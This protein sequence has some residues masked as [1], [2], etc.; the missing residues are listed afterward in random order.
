MTHRPFQPSVDYPPLAR[1]LSAAGPKA[2][3]PA[4][5]RAQDA[6]LP[7][8]GSLFAGPDGLLTGFGR[9][10]LVE[11]GP[12]GELAAFATAWRAPWTP[13]G[14]IASLVVGTKDLAP[15]RLLPLMD[16]LERWARG[17]GARRLLGELAQGHAELLRLAIA[18]GHRIDAHI[19]TATA[20]LD[21]LPPAVP[22]PGIRLGTLA[23]TSAPQPA[24]QLYRLYRETLRDNPGFVDALPDFDH[25]YAEAVAGEG[26]RPDW[27]FTAECAGRIV[28]VSTA[29]ATRD[30][31]TCHIDYTGVLR[32]WRG[33]GLARSLKLHAARRLAGHGVR[34]VH[35]E[36]E[37]GN[38]PM[39]AVNS[40]LG[41]RWG[42]GH[43]RLV[44]QL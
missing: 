36:V 29:R 6:Q 13:P 39:V 33:R 19:R 15:D 41:Y 20:R 10:R 18:R 24:L 31:R 26:C 8:T 17:A 16:A 42:P 21:T 4:E 27:M 28:G 12:D 22:P 3:T 44:K 5:L 40:A 37:A 43:H 34:T 23:T 32:P 25:W 2:V 9:I 38:A 30:P 14:D 7:P 1:L 35:T 11:P